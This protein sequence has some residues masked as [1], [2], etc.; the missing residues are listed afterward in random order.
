MA[1]T[2]L[3]AADVHEQRQVRED[4]YRYLEVAR[5]KL[6]H[7]EYVA[8]IQDDRDR[9]MPA[10]YAQ[11]VRDGAVKAKR[12]FAAERRQKATREAKKRGERL[13]NYVYFIR[14]EDAVKVGTSRNPQRRL[15]VMQTAHP[16]KLEI[17]ALRVGDSKM[18]REYH[19][20]F[21]PFRLRG[22][23]F[24]PAPEIL[25]EI[26]RLKEPAA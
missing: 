22:E 6:T 26:D 25:A 13:T 12:Q 18:E 1:E 23:W 10:V 7:T 19:R 21:A 3:P 9:M 15:A 14:S 11:G 17:A 4:Q 20:R 16:G 8:L 5:N 24:S 2:S